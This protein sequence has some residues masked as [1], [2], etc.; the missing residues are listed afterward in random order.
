MVLE[1]IINN[2]ELQSF[3]KFKGFEEYS[4]NTLEEK[5]EVLRIL[6]SIVYHE[7][8]IYYLKDVDINDALASLQKK[9]DLI[10]YGIIRNE[11][12]NNA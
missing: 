3:R 2:G 10:K 1:E 7:V 5:E 4:M 9:F 12:L 6:L 8:I 11:E